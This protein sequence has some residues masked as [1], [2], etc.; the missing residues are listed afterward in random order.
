M[1]C[2]ERMLF[3]HVP[4]TAGMAVSEVLL[5][6]L[7]RPVFYSVPP[8]HESPVPGVTRVPGRRHEFLHEALK[9]MDDLHMESERLSVILAGMRNP[10]EME[11]S[12]YFYLRVGNAWDRGP[13]Q[14]LAMNGS[15]EQFAVESP[16]HGRKLPEIEK[17]YTV[18]GVAH[19]KLHILRVERLKG[20]LSAGLHKAGLAVEFDV[21]VVNTTA[22]GPW[23]QYLTPRAE[24]AIYERFRWLFDKGYYQRPGGYAVLKNNP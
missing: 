20:D 4:K 10:Y 1:I 11:V 23:E 17:Y 9:I 13:A 7:P 15:F 18:D 3:V 6:I 5:R 21:P 12:R 19:P 8:D 24:Q 2:C 22:H 16:Y 14:T